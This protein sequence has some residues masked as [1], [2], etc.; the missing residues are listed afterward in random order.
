MDWITVAIQAGGAMAVCAMFLFY[1][2]KKQKSDE[3]ARQ[4]FLEHLARKDAICG[5][6]INQQMDYLKSR[7]QQSREL[8]ESGFAALRE[9]SEKIDTLR[10]EIRRL[11]SGET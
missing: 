10:V 3:A 8:A 7:D 6:E 11:P 2:D 9:L 4:N 5:E 1:L